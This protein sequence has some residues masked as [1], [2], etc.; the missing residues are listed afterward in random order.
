MSQFYSDPTR[1][2]DPHSLPDCEVFQLTATEVA[3][4]MEDKQYEYLK[5]P[6]FRLASFNSKTRAALLDAMVE[7][8]GIEGG[9]F[10]Q[11]RLPGC[12]PDGCPVGPFNSK[13]D[14]IADAQNQ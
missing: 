14:A 10:W 1:E 9:W 4:S 11:A 12:L 5:K 7:D 3:E 13:A 2:S 6:A 8:L